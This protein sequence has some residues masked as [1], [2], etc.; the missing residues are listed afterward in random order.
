[1][2]IRDSLY[3]LTR[4]DNVSIASI[5]NF[6][7]FKQF[8]KPRVRSS[9]RDR[10]IVFPPYNAQQ[11]VDILHERSEMSF[12]DG[13]LNNDVIPLCAALA[14][15]E[16][17][18][19]RYALDLLRTSGELADE[20]ASETVFENYVREAKDYICLLYTSPSPR[21]RTRSRMPSS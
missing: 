7:D 15:K 20:R 21:D 1:M 19:A 12:K 14:A 10:E 8:I 2:C 16:E 13:V 9:L 5:S 17:G 4:T 3:T 11:L 18:D 6:V